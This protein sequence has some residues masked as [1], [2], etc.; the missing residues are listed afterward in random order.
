MPVE[1]KVPEVGES[2]TEVHIAQWRKRVG[3][4]VEKDENLVEIE[5]DKA[6]VD[7]P[8]PISGTLTEIRKE[9][10][11]TARI[12]EIIGTMTAGSEAAAPA[13]PQSPPAKTTEPPAQPQSTSAPAG[14]SESSTAPRVMPAAER[15]MAA[16]KISADAV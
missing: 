2:I 7:M 13:A 9:A 14:R 3:Q 10:G 5:S 1:L 12:G 11:E 15:L 4:R 16:Q 6:T 8:A